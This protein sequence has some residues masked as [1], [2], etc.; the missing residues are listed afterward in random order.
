MAV[1]H[2]DEGNDFKKLLDFEKLA[3]DFMKKWLRYTKS[4]CSHSDSS[5][6][7]YRVTMDAKMT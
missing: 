3:T 5:T 6:L 7:T 2:E 4:F 1:N